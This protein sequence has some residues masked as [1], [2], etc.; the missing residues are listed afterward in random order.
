MKSFQQQVHQEA[1]AS[2]PFDHR[3]VT[4]KGRRNPS[5]ALGLLVK[6]VVLTLTLSAASSLM[7][8]S[9]PAMLPTSI[10]AGYIDPAGKVPAINGV[11]GSQVENLDLS[12]PVAQLVQGVRYVYSVSVQ[13]N[14][15]TGSC[16]VSYKLTQ[17]QSGK[18]VTL[19]S[20]NITTFNTSPG[21]I[22]IWVATGKPIPNSPGVATLTGTFKCGSNTSSIKTT[23]V[24]Q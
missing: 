14:T 1:V 23:V 17:V 6:V 3:T 10:T 8:Q 7:A 22:W 20:A 11:P 2:V 16:T 19:D 24:L 13:D 4:A 9:G 21:N 12:F 5:R 18:T 15:Y